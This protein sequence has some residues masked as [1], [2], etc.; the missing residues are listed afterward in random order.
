[1]KRLR[2]ILI[3]HSQPFVTASRAPRDAIST[4]YH[5]CRVQRA[6]NTSPDLGNPRWFFCVP[7]IGI[8]PGWMLP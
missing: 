5:A 2:G 7:T 4:S 3:P 8:R 6:L 1:M